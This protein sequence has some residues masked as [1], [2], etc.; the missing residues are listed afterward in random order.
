MTTLELLRRAKAAKGAMALAGTEVKNRAL[1]AMAEGLV[2]RASAI[3]EANALDL[4]AAR[5]TVSGVMLDRLALDQGRIKGMADG[6][7]EVADLPD[8]VG[9]VLRRE[10]RPTDW[11]L[12]RPPCPWGLWPSFTRAAPTSPPTRRRWR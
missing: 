8:P 6:V 4:A 9:R 5:G 10:E 12:K 3:L 7:R 11:S 2:A 1:A